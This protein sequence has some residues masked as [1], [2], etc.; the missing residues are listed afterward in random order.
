MKL[1][2]CEKLEKSMARAAVLYWTRRPS[3]PPSRRRLQARGQKVRRFP[4]SARAR[5]P[6]AMIEK[7]Y[8]KD[9]FHYDAV[10]DLFPESL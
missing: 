8:G 10:N 9:I 6:S 7:M 3:N 5:R 2:S 1:I 4:A